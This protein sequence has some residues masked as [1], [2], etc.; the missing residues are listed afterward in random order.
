[1]PTRPPRIAPCLVLALCAA[2]AL[3]AD[4][5]A[6]APPP[7]DSFFTRSLHFT[8]RGIEFL[9]A[10]EQG[11]VGTITGKTAAEAGCVQAK[12][13][14]AS[15][16]ACHRKDAGGKSSYTL[17]PAVAQAAC[18]GCHDAATPET[19]VHAAKG[20]RCMS[21][22]SVREVHGDGVAYDTYSQAGALD[23]RCE[24]CHASIAR[25][26]S[27][28]V[29]GGK[30]DCSA[31]HTL[32]APSCL[33]CH[34]DATREAKKDNQIPLDGV[35]F[36]V[37]HGGRVTTAN[38]LSFVSGKRTMVTLAPNFAH[39]ITR[40]GR[41]CGDCHA[42]E[43]VARIAADTLAPARLEAG[44]LASVRGV[45]PAVEGMTWRLPFLE[46]TANGWAPIAGAEPPIVHFSGNCAP[47]T[48]EQLARLVAPRASH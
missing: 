14:V 45:V 28:T 22:H 8:N 12:C 42:S 25:T 9:Y 26:A 34:L 30:L 21:C 17:D 1:M 39:S 10:R 31:C 23:T 11:G 16:D 40:A 36:L 6:P 24:S 46:R 4:P 47:L 38:L 29:H 44:K 20:M 33:N 18:E 2:G 43:I 27:H 41:T 15:C 35:L 32:A 37:N 5:P 48:K 13:H 3:A 7:S 19:D